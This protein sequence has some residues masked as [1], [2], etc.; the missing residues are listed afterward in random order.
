MIRCRKG[1]RTP[2]LFDLRRKRWWETSGILEKEDV[3]AP[4]P[5]TDEKVAAE[6]KVFTF[7]A[8]YNTGV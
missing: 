5:T 8:N 4:K 3:A 7:T 2:A 6:N 1:R